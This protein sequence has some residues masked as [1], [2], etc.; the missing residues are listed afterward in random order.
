MVVVVLSS[1][2]CG[3]TAPSATPEVAAIVVSPATP[4]LALDAQLPLQAEVRDGSG[5]IVPGAAVTWTVQDP[6]IVSI[7]AAG[8]VKALAVGTSQVAANALGKS[9]IAVVTVATPATTGPV[10]PGNDDSGNDDP[11]EEDPAEEDPGDNDSGNDDSGDDDSGDDSPGPVATVTVT[12]PSKEL[13]TGSRMTL[14]ATAK[15]A[16]GNPVSQ[17]SFV[18]SSSNTDKASVTAS[19]VVTAKEPGSVTITARTSATGGKS[20]SVKIQIKKR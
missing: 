5:A 13:D 17:Q 12:A 14:T 8:V 16:K 4:T 7:S 15:D 1:W 2:A 10:N 11:A 20:G 3:S 9:G 6:G 19:G 18:W